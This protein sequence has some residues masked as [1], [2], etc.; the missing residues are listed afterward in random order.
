MK[1]ERA[2]QLIDQQEQIPHPINTD[3]VCIIKDFISY[4]DETGCLWVLIR[5]GGQ[6]ILLFK[7]NDSNFFYMVG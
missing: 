4:E 3:N 7:P 5:E 6:S 1:I 2:I